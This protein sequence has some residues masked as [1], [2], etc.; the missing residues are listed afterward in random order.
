MKRG[1]RRLA[2]LAQLSENVY[3]WA[4]DASGGRLQVLRR[5]FEQFGEARAAQAAAA[6]AYYAMFSLFPLLLALVAAVGFFVAG[7]RARQEVIGFVE[8]AIPVSRGL[9][10]RNVRNVLE[11]RGAVGIVGLV[12]LLWSASGMFTVLAHNVNRAWPGAEPRSFLG[13]R[14]VGLA[15][16]G[17]LALLLGLSLMSSAVLNL[18][19]RLRVPLWNGV[20]VYE[21][22]LWEVVS[23]LVPWLFTFLLFFGLYLWVPSVAVERRAAFWGAVAAAIAWEL[24]KNGFVLYL[25][26]GLV[27][28]ELVYGS[29]GAVVALMLWNYLGSWIALFGAH[30]SAAIA[31]YLED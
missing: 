22:A 18:L 26:S 28:Y 2:N 3:E 4:N 14:L 12:G 29:L 1:D 30:L 27:Q 25:G 11:L 7:E 19:P 20:S 9:I 8:T 6:M 16:V 13:R 15:M 21:T 31:G 17:S 10:S 5:T 23:R 24:V